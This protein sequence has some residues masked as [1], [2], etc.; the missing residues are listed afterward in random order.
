MSRANSEISDSIILGV[1][2]PNDTDS[3]LVVIYSVLKVN[4]MSTVA[5]EI[6]KV[7]K[8]SQELIIAGDLN[9]RTGKKGNDLTVGKFGKR[10]LTTTANDLSNF[11]N[12]MY[13]LP[14]TNGFNRHKYIHKFTWTQ[15]TRNVRSTVDYII[16]RYENQNQRCQGLS[17]PVV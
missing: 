8:K 10:T 7:K 2:G 14:I 1:Y 5:E 9:G 3:V 4:F 17:P 16:V 12:Y 6:S 11:A 13:N 15:E